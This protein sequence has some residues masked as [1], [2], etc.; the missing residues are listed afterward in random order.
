MALQKDA[1]GLIQ[2]DS[3]QVIRSQAEILNDG[4]LAQKVV[5]VGGNLVP[6]V[7]DSIALTYRVSAPGLGEIDTVVYKLGVVTVATLVLTYDGSNR[8]IGVVRS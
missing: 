3:G 2:L 8:L 6:K 7:Y 5:S 4:S 1:A